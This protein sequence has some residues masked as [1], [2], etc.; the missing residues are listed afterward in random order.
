M[1]DPSNQL[2][3]DEF[4]GL[5]R[6]V[7]S[8][9]DAADLWSQLARQF[10]ASGR[11]AEALAAYDQVLR[12]LPNDA[13]ALNN[14]AHLLIVNGQ[15]EAAMQRLDRVVTLHPELAEAYLNRG[16]IHLYRGRYSLATAEYQQALQVRPDYAEAWNNL[17]SSYREQ[18][19][20]DQ[21]IKHFQ[22][23]IRLRSDFLDAWINLGL[24]SYDQDLPEQAL[25]AFQ[26]ALQLAPQHLE[27]LLHV[28][29]LKQQLCCWP[30]LIAETQ[31]LLGWWGAAPE[32]RS[33][34]PPFPL[35]VLHLE[36]LP[37]LHREAAYRWTDGPQGLFS[38]GPFA[39][40]SAPPPLAPV[41]GIPPGLDHLPLTSDS[42]PRLTASS[43][44]F[45]VSRQESTESP[46]AASLPLPAPGQR[47]IRIGYLSADYRQHPTAFLVSE[48]FEQHDR[49]QVEVF[50]YS[51]GPNDRSP[52]RARI[53]R[54]VDTF[55]ELAPLDFRQAAEAI[56]RDQID[57]LIDLKGL[58]QYART[59][60]LGYRPALIQVNYLGY[61]STMGTRHIDYAIV[62]AFV[63]PEP[64]SPYFAETLV[65]LPG[66]YQCNESFTEFPSQPPT[67]AECGLSDTA[68]VFCAFNNS[69]KLS[70]TMF[71]LWMEL[72]K[73]TPGS[74]LWL[75]RTSGTMEDN[76]RRQAYQ[77]GVAPER[78]VF[79]PSVPRSMHLARMQQ[80]DLFLDTFPCSAHT[81]ASDA[82]RV[83]LPLLT[84]V[85]QAFVSRVAG[86]LL[87]TLGIPELITT[88]FG[89][90][91]SR[92]RALAANPEWLRRL[93]HQIL[94][95]PGYA[96]IFSGAAIARKLEIA[97]QEMLC[98]AR[99]A[100]PRRLI[101]LR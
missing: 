100:G 42:L 9:P 69:Y 52:Y 60:I 4:A 21:A 10:Q 38:Q 39:N 86:S 24:V 37:S 53:E 49:R 95:S 75:L 15:D 25:A 62:D 16:N 11:N 33:A 85:G 48:L 6:A 72:L 12:I 58:T 77:R 41:Q 91:A 59:E 87:N 23:A 36:T 55:R 66:C 40:S 68:F 17:G 54:G 82:L 81:T 101:D 32:P 2:P 74:L 99:Q 14:T 65:Y 5:R 18:H 20:H 73:A 46:A 78:L 22:Q 3:E 90:Y 84:L 19:L 93:R 44:A 31:R 80:A 28:I 64:Q 88:D 79:A 70:Q 97:Y 34:L 56:R 43:P 13:E 35:L 27:V 45:R 63:V 7:R 61:P 8:Q 30:G 50:A 26:A 47:R 67:R 94:N 96:D 89:Q 76:L 83:G 29:H 71:D 1:A 98:Q 51:Y 57:I 92:A